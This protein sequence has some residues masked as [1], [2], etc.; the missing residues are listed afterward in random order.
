MPTLLRQLA[1]AALVA[2]ATPAAAVPSIADYRLEMDVSF[3]GMTVGRVE[4]SAA[5]IGGD[6]AQSFSVET[7]GLVRRLTGFRSEA[8]ALSRLDGAKLATRSFDTFS[9]NKRA[10]R[11][12]AVR[13]DE[14][15]R[16]VDL[17]SLKRG[18]PDA[19]EVPPELRNDTIDPLTAIP[20]IRVW[21]AGVRDEGSGETTIAVFDGRRR[22]DLDVVLNERRTAAFAD[23]PTPI[24]DVTV[25][26][27]PIAGFD[28]DGRRRVT[29]LVS[30]DDALLP[31]IM[32]T[33]PTSGIQGSVYTRRACLGAD[34]SVCQDFRY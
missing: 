34:E 1:A 18:R 22:Y 21:L 15:G 8:T 17:E 30:D 2:A 7:S 25:D 23:G 9:E 28:D 6:L 14:R 3:L 27:R 26:L 5:D 19:S 10:T 16:V 32:R 13:W 4:L 11:E 20:T 33:A 12:V 31:L 29:V 24:L